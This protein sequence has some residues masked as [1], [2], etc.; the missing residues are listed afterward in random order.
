MTTQQDIEKIALRRGIYYPSSEIH[1]SLAGFYDYGT[2][3]KKIKNNFENYWRD[4]FLKGLN[5]NFH[6]METSTIMPEKVFEASGHLK[7]FVDPVVKCSKCKNTEKADQVLEKELN[8]SF[9]G[10]TPEQF[11]EVIEEH[12]IK[13]HKCGGEL[14]DADEINLMFKVEVGP[15]TKQTAYLRPE[16]A[17]GMFTAFKR[18]YYA[19][20]EKLPLGLAQ[21]GRAYRN[22]I[23]PRQDLFRQREFTQ[24]EIQI[25]FNPN[26][27]EEH[28]NFDE[29]KH[30]EVEVV[31]AGQSKETQVKTIQQMNEEGKPRMYLYYLAKIH[32]FYQSLGITKIRLYEKSKEEKAFYNKI[33]FDFEAYFKS[34]GEY[35]EIAAMH[36]RTDYDL[37]KHGQKSGEKMKITKQGQ[38]FIPHVMEITFGIDRNI[39]I[40][41][42]KYH[43]EEDKRTYI[44][45]PKQVSPQL[46][47]VLP[48]VSK[49]G[50]PEKA[51]EVHKQLNTQIDVYYDD[52]G[53]IGKRYRRA[54]EV[55]VKYCIT[56]D[57]DTLEDNAVTVRERDTMEQERIN[58]EELTKHLSR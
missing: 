51:E 54:D 35:K 29:I 28:P 44:A 45:L 23:S 17:Q 31:P 6:E 26:K 47:A 40:L 9:E 50:L 48:L 7:Q 30:I 32:Q 8:E 36:Y 53:S 10:L 43:K 24:A 25:F 22:E 34:Y 55:G 1:G 58:I 37:K 38:R 18:E 14:E 21:I 57:Y 56:V 41:L 5:E 39:L 19:N 15:H 49:D 4:F 27:L 13:C 2:V 3:G 20:R 12:Q 11:R 52:S 42:D 46:A 16:T 33:Q